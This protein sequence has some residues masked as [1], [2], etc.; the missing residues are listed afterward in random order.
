[1]LNRYVTRSDLL[2]QRTLSMGD[3]N[4]SKEEHR[5]TREKFGSHYGF[6]RWEM[7]VT[8]TRLVVVKV[9]KMDGLVVG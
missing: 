2:A 6:L 4:R 1:M 5:R 7:V 8:W 3:E 9:D